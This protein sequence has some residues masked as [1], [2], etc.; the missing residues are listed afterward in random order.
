MFLISAM[1]VNT[2]VAASLYLAARLQT[3]DALVPG[4]KADAKQKDTRLPL[5]HNDR[6]HLLPPAGVVPGTSSTE[7]SENSHAS[8]ACEPG[9]CRGF[10]GGSVWRDPTVD[11][12]VG[13]RSLEAWSSRR[14]SDALR[15]LGGCA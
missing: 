8:T 1:L 6:F 2:A 15:R 10:E 11:L 7:V 13:D 4:G 3:R 14:R 9:Q 5:K 12:Q